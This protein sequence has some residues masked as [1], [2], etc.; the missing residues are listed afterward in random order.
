MS[1]VVFESSPPFAA[2]IST[3]ASAPRLVVV[4]ETGCATLCAVGRHSLQSAVQFLVHRN[5][6][7]DVC[8]RD[9]T[10]IAT[11]SSDHTARVV[12]V[13]RLKVVHQLVG[14]ADTVRAIRC[15]PTQPSECPWGVALP[16]SCD[17]SLARPP[18]S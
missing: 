7:L 12:N 13:E 16:S 9:D 8:W 2:A 15:M 18:H 14:H 1:P 11:A 17:S 5:A 6:I 3:S 10:S 4:D